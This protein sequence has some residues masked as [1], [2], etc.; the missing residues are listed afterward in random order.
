MSADNRDGERVRWIASEAAARREPPPAGLFDQATV[1]V[2]DVCSVLARRIV[3]L[4][5]QK[6]NKE[7]S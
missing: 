2:I 7:A 5:S 4:E 6:E 3:Q 1:G